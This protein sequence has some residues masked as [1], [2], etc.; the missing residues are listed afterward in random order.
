MSR[1]SGKWHEAVAKKYLEQ[2]GLK[3]IEKNFHA[4]RGELDLIMQDKQTLV[5]VEVRFRKNSN[6]GSPA[7]S[8]TARKQQHM[9]MAAQRFLLLNPKMAETACRFDV[10]A[11]TGSANSENKPKIDWIKNAFLIT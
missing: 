2:Q 1:E 8:V 3:L 5:F 7:E 9:T 6:Y 4:Y 11:I 10:V